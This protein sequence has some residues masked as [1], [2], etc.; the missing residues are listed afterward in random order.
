M[1]TE[2]LYQRN[3]WQF[4]HAS[5]SFQLALT[6][7]VLS[8]VVWVFFS[9]KFCRAN[10]CFFSLDRLI[11]VAMKITFFHVLFSQFALIDQ[12]FFLHC[13]NIHWAMCLEMS[14]LLEPLGGPYI[15]HLFWHLFDFVSAGNIMSCQLE[16]KP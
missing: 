1:F 16:K 4:I 14:S 15:F 8:S 5:I 3:K 7:F 12:F 10:P 2:V 6:L 11:S 9:S 13:V